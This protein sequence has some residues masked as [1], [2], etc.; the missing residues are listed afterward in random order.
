MPLALRLSF[1][2]P[3]LSCIGHRLEGARFI[4]APHTQPH[5]LTEQ[6]GILD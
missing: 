3:R 4:L 6:V 1:L 5:P 2:G